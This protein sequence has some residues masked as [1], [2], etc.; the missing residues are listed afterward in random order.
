MMLCDRRN[1]T[2]ANR[3]APGLSGNTTIMSGVTTVTATNF[4]GG[5]N[6]NPGE[7]TTSA[8][9][10]R[11]GALMTGPS[12]SSAI[13]GDG[14]LSA[15]IDDFRFWKTNRNARQIGTNYFVN[16]GGGANTDISNAELGVY[17]KFNEGITNT[18]SVDSIVLD[19]AGRVTNAIWTGYDSSSRTQVPQSYWR[20]AATKEYREPVVRRNHP[21]FISLQNKFTSYRV[22]I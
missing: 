6:K 8:M 20:G 18:N 2:I 10:G 5:I 14:T 12:G 7:I 17:Y 15:S 1:W 13:A 21:S 11:I 22:C 16:V 4:T 3:Y 9:L 19:Y